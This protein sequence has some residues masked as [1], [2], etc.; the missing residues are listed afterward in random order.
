MPTDPLIYP[1]KESPWRRSRLVDDQRSSFD[2]IAFNYGC[3]QLGWL[4]DK[5]G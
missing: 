3:S 1:S 2:S 5:F 4:V